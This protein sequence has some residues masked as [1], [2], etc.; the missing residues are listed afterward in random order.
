VGFFFAL[1]LFFFALG[2]GLAP[3]GRAAIGNARG[4]AP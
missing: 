4:L 1:A 2:T 3:I